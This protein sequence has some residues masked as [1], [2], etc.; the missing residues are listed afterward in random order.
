MPPELAE[1]FGPLLRALGVREAFA[2]VDFARALTKYALDGD[3][4][5]PCQTAFYVL[6]S[7]HDFCEHGATAAAHDR[8]VH[9]FEPFCHSCHGH[10]ELALAAR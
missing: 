3:G 5:Q 1:P 2:P 4:I 9:D 8:L 10:K 6:Q 7:H